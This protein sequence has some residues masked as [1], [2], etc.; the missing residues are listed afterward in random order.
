[1]FHR[2]LLPFISKLSQNRNTCFKVIKIKHILF[3][4][5]MERTNRNLTII[6]ISEENTVKDPEENINQKEK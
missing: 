2:M 6:K 5:I 1:M 3:P 4:N